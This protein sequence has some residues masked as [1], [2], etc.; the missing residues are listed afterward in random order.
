MAKFPPYPGASDLLL[1]RFAELV[2]A[3]GERGIQLA[4][5]ENLDGSAGFANQAVAIN[6]SGVTVSPAGKAL[7][8]STFTTAYS[9]WDGLWKPR[10]G[11]AGA[12]A[13]GRP[14]NPG[15]A[16]SP[17]AISGLC[18]LSRPSCRASSPSRGPRAPCGAAIPWR[19]Q[20]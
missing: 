2:R 8:V 5:A 6:S 16:N 15:A 3:H 9:K 19:L 14:Q 18:C 17:C 12:A 1:G 20:I 7:S 13:S 11:S 4:V 10:F